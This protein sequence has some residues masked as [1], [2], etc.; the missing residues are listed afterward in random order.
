MDLGPPEY[1]EDFLNIWELSQFVYFEE[2]NP[3]VLIH[4]Y[5]C[6]FRKAFF[7]SEY[8][9]KFSDIAMGPEIGEQPYALYT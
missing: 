7:F 1:P 3:A 6:P 4:N 2:H 8:A 9:V 5:V